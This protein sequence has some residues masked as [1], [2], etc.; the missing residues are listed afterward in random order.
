MERFTARFSSSSIHFDIG[1][2]SVWAGDFLKNVFKV[3]LR[4]GDDPFERAHFLRGSS[5][6]KRK[7]QDGNCR[8]A[9]D[10]E[11]VEVDMRNLDGGREVVLNVDEVNRS[12]SRN[13]CVWRRTAIS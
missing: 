3:D 10:G 4:S 7:S 11:C 1:V 2:S 6:K 5:S 12:Q 8:E 9:H 13:S